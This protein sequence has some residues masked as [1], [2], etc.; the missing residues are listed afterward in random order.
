VITQAQVALRDAGGSPRGLS[1]LYSAAAN[2]HN[3]LGDFDA[4]ARD[5][6]LSLEAARRSQNPTATAS[7]QFARAVALSRDDPAAA[8]VA[9]DESIA[10]GRL[11]TSGGLL[12]FALARRSV[13]RAETG[14]LAGARR[15]AREAVKHGHERGDRPMLT[16]A[17][18]CTLAVL[19]A[20]GHDEAAA[21]LAGAQAAGVASGVSRPLTGGLVGDLGLAAD[22]LDEV[23]ETLGDDLYADATGRGAAMTLD[24]T[25]A[26]VL[27]VLD[28][29]VL[30]VP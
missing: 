17:L 7:A 9:L 21:V 4:A 13:L 14:D 11:G 27:T 30:A 18:D 10:I 12:G 8:A 20:I 29:A 22:A 19:H 6:E 3:L 25:V 1:F 5:A 2:F 26:Y 15:D 28:V 23:R 16:A 24:D